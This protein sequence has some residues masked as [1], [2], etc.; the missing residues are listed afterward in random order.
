MEK[1]YTIDRLI[2]VDIEPCEAFP[3]GNDFCKV[4]IEL[5]GRKLAIWTTV[6]NI[7][8]LEFDQQQ[9]KKAR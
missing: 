9:K 3:V 8:A 2:V 1:E 7:K 6:S 5:D 4:V